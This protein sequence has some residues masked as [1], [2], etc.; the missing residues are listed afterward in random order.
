MRK[1]FSKI[2]FPLLITNTV[3]FVADIITTILP[4]F[5]VFKISISIYNLIASKNEQFDTEDGDLV[6]LIMSIIAIS[7]WIGLLCNITGLVFCIINI[8]KYRKYQKYRI[9]KMRQEEDEQNGYLS[10]F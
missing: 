2:Y 5:L 6:I 9:R 7:P 10:G 4:V 3:F 1:V 8:V